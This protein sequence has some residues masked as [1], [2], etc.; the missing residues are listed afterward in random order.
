[1]TLEP[2][3]PRKVVKRILSLHP[4][5][6]QLL[7]ETDRQARTE[8]KPVFAQLSHRNMMRLIDKVEN[9]ILTRRQIKRDEELVNWG[10]TL[11]AEEFERVKSYLA[12]LPDPRDPSV[13]VAHLRRMLNIGV[14]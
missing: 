5:Q 8:G 4:R 11:S 13:D 1:M 2:H 3:L 14:Q 9:E 7:I 12:S 10:E 6:R